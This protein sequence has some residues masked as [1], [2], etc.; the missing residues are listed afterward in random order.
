MVVVNERV[1]F[2]CGSIIRT[3]VMLSKNI[4]LVTGKFKYFEYVQYFV[5]CIHVHIGIHP[6]P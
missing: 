2:E 4:L 1:L 3:L 6:D 5:L